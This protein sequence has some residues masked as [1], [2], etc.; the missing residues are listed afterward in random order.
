M[1][2]T[3]C[4]IPSISELSVMQ[5]EVS[6]GFNEGRGGGPR[7]LGEKRKRRVYKGDWNG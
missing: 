6:G 1:L 3:C 2:H 4:A 7:G 5:L